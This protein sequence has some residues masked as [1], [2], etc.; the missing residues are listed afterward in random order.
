MATT[1]QPFFQDLSQQRSGDA[2]RL[3]GK[4]QRYK[5]ELYQ[6]AEIRATRSAKWGVMLADRDYMRQLNRD[7]MQQQFALE[8]GAQE[9]GARREAA[10]VERGFRR[11]EAGVEREFRT[12][13][14]ETQQEF[15]GRQA[16]LGRTLPGERLRWEQDQAEAKARR[17]GALGQRLGV[18]GATTASE[19]NMGLLLRSTEDKGLAKQRIE[20]MK[21]ELSEANPKDA[22]LIAH[23][24]TINDF[25][26][27]IQ[28][29]KD[30]ARAAQKELQKVVE[31]QR[32]R[33]VEQRRADISA[34]KSA[35]SAMRA[36]F[37]IL[38]KQPGRHDLVTAGAWERFRAA[39]LDAYIA[40]Y[41]LRIPTGGAITQGPKILVRHKRTGQPGRIPESQ[42]DPAKFERIEP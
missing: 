13:L 36:D 35:E 33:Q 27:Y 42:F 19:L 29:Q 40:R 24:D 26:T 6:L 37:N 23:F 9:I 34:L 4:R 21:L 28:Q 20:S 1:N 18:S 30:Q 14:L 8:R 32:I 11:E 41:A 39:N 15:A 10:G 12:E 3:A 38:K 31:Q 16:E 22:D 5:S 17:I 7:R 25:Q 2:Q